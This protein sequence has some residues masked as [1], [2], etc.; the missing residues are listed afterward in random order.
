MKK[1]G[2]YLLR[3]VDSDC[4]YVGS[5]GDLNKRFARHFNELKQGIHH[6]V[7]LQ[8]QWNDG[9]EMEKWEFLTQSRERAYQ[10]EQELINDYLPSGKLLN[11]GMSVKGGD[12][13]TLHPDRDNIILKITTAQ[14]NRYALMTSEERKAKHGSIGKSNGMY[15]R[16]HSEEIRKRISDKNKANVTRNTEGGNR[17]RE[18]TQSEQGRTFISGL[19][20]L[21]TGDKNPFFGKTHSEDAKQKMRLARMGKKPANQKPVSINGI[22][23]NSATEAGRQLGCVTA[24]ILHRIKSKNPKYKDYRYVTECPTTSS[25]T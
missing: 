17:L 12:N 24:T 11:I 23:Y 10:I 2:A 5:S 6:N 25:S 13:I 1:C 22:V 18:F 21:R 7:K 4:V 14:H 19:A 3:C 9:V 15:G 16:T 8:E 20:R